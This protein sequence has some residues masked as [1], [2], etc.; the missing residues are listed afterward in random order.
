MMSGIG[1][2]AGGKGGG[3]RFHLG[4]RYVLVKSRRDLV[5]GMRHRARRSTAG[6]GGE[7]NSRSGVRLSALRRERT[8]IEL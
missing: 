8:S 7:R 5:E 3:T 6:A 2:A 1:D 4:S